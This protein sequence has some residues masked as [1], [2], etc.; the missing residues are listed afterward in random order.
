MLGLHQ[1]DGWPAR[2][3]THQSWL[4]DYGGHTFF[5]Q[6]F[7]G[8]PMD[9]LGHQL[10]LVA[11]DCSQAV[12][13]A[14][15][16]DFNYTLAKA[17][18]NGSSVESEGQAAGQILN[19]FRPT[20]AAFSNFD[21]VHQIN[22][23]FRVDVQLVG[24]GDSVRH[25]ACVWGILADAPDGRRP[26]RTGFPFPTSSGKWLFFP[27]QYLSMAPTLKPGAALPEV[28]VAKNAQ[29]GPNI[30]ANPAKAYDSFQYTRSGFR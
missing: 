16:A 27:D 18:D 4:Y 29:G 15:Q 14:V 13:N 12:S 22:S 10:S 9:N 20:V 2:P 6:Q 1:L 30:F 21:I 5:Q 11:I 7:D 17:L 24:S 25:E 26:L 19:A 23:N 8:C 28:G 3:G